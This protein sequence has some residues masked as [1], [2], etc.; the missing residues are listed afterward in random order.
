MLLNFNNDL[1]NN[2]KVLEEIT[3]TIAYSIFD[4][5]NVKLNFTS[6]IYNNSYEYD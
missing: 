6:T 5:Y 4:T 1:F 3:Y 2:E